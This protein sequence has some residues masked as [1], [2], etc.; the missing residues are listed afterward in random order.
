MLLVMKF[1]GALMDGCK[2]VMRSAELVAGQLKQG[3]RVVVVVSAMSGVTDSLISAAEKAARGDAEE[4]KR[5]VQSIEQQHMKVAEEVAPPDIMPALKAEVRDLTSSLNQILTSV[6][7]LKELSSRSLDLICSFGERLS[8]PLM[9]AALIKLGVRAVHLT[10]GE[11]GIVTTSNFGAAKPIMEITT[12]K[13]R[14]KL[15]PIIEQGY[16]PVVTGFIAVD[17]NGVVTT[18]G[19]GGSDYTATILAAALKADE[20]WIWKDVDGVM[21]ADPKL[22]RNARSIKNL[23]Y[24][25]AMEL[26]YFG[27]KVLH[28]LTVTPLL[29]QGIPIRIKNALNPSFDG[30]IISSK[31]SKDG[32]V[33]AVTTIRDTAIITIGGAGMV[34]APSVIA[35]AF[36]AL[37]REAVDVLMVSQSSSM[38]NISIVVL[39]KD[40]EKAVGALK[41]EFKEGNVVREISVKDGVCVVAAVGEGMRGTPGVAAKVFSSVAE[42]G[43]NILMISQGSSELNISF[44]IE[45]RDLLTAVQ[46]VHNAFGL[47]EL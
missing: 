42:K 7:Y 31:S 41:S 6:S 47:S 44:A 45:E 30:T 36:S 18:L 24:E 21:T 33:K 26:A 29:E 17:R 10:G 37:A 9:W 13:V 40:L 8:A 25:E 35:R 34:G 38:A 43:V 39:K 14:E 28:P 11:A 19:R 46:A 5:A 2:N 12:K 27:A 16:T 20:V 32:V 15:T 3:D 4:V 22:V 1:G 23:S